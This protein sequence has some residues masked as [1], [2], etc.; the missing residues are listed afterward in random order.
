M[1]AQ[2]HGACT[3]IGG[4]NTRESVKIWICQE[5]QVHSQLRVEGVSFR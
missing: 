1:P 2:W 3:A 4:K 5:M